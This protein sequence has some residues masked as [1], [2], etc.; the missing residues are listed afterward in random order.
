MTDYV[1]VVT[2]LKQTG[3]VKVRLGKQEFMLKDVQPGLREWLLFVPVKKDHQGNHPGSHVIFCHIDRRP[4]GWRYRIEYRFSVPALTGDW[5]YISVFIRRWRSGNLILFC[6]FKWYHKRHFSIRS[7]LNISR[8]PLLHLLGG[9]KRNAKAC[10]LLARTLLGRY[11]EYFWR[12]AEMF[13]ERH[14]RLSG[15]PVAEAHRL[16]VDVSAYVCTQ[17][18]AMPELPEGLTSRI[19]RKA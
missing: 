11:P 3:D 16:A 2:M 12:I 9:H 4:A 7:F 19:A 15:M 14:P 17:N 5:N 13:G 8:R 18:G 10:G 6:F 1:H